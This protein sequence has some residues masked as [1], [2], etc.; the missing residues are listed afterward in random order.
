[1]KLFR[2]M[3]KKNMTRNYLSGNALDKRHKNTTI[4]NGVFGLSVDNITFKNV[5]SQEKQRLKLVKS[6]G[7]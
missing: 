7:K 1:M 5:R 4:G 6:K 2:V 3:I